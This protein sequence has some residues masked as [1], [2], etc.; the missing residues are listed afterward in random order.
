MATYTPEEIVELADDL[1]KDIASS[2]DDIDAVL[3]A[4][5]ADRCAQIVKNLA[6]CVAELHNR[7]DIITEK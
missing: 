3:A 7:V 5:F 2:K 6:E 1:M 4:N